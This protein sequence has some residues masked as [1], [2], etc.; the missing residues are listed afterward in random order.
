MRD[1]RAFVAG[2]LIGMFLLSQQISLQPAMATHKNL[3]CTAIGWTEAIRESTDVSEDGVQADIE[4]Y[5]EP[6]GLLSESSAPYSRGRTTTTSLRPGGGG[7]LRRPATST[8][9]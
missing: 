5:Y 3:I 9:G 7:R 4:L 8:S 2:F 6:G 1:R